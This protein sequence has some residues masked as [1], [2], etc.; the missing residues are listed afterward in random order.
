MSSQKHSFLY[1]NSLSIVF[2]V[3][4][5][6]SLGGQYVTGWHQYN[7]NREEHGQAPIDPGAYLTTENFVSST[8]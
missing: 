2:T 5:L 7:E 1:R 3:L 6:I 4:M 8:F